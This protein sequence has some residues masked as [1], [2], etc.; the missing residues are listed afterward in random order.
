[1][2]ETNSGVQFTFAKQYSNPFITNCTDEPTSA[3]FREEAI[4]NDPPEDWYGLEYTLVSSRLDRRGSNDDPE[5]S[6]GEHSK[7]CILRLLHA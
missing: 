3:L 2:P 6:T 5:T 7:V 4:G 1:M